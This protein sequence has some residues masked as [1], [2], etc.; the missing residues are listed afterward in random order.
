MCLIVI[1]IIDLIFVMLYIIFLVFFCCSQWWFHISMQMQMLLRHKLVSTF[2]DQLRSRTF[3][4][5]SRVFTWR[6]TENILW[7]WYWL[8]VISMTF[9]WP[10]K[11]LLTPVIF[12]EWISQFPWYFQVFQDC[13]NRV[14]LMHGCVY[15]NNTKTVLP[16]TQTSTSRY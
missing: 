12:H 7:N 6:N 2:F 15:T 10:F 14:D 4:S 13:G 3:S 16:T 9:P 11:M 8:K 5:Y 1:K